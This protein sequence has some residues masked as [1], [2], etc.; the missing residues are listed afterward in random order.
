MK[1][2]NEGKEAMEKEYDCSSVKEMQDN[3]FIGYSAQDIIA[4]MNH[5][6]AINECNEAG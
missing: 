5:C 4:A 1:L 6:G 2:T 3:Y